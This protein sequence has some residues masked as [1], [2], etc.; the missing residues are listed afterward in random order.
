[1]LCVLILRELFI[2]LR[3]FRRWY[4]GAK[5]GRIERETGGGS[6]YECEWK[7]IVAKDYKMKYNADYG[8]CFVEAIWLRRRCVLMSKI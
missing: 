5:K 3:N 8:E 6:G 1:M 7:E 4:R 2:C